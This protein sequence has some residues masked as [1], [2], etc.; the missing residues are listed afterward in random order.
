MRIHPRGL[1]YRVFTR[2]SFGGWSLYDLET[3]K[4][5]FPEAEDGL[6]QW[7]KKKMHE[8]LSELKR[9]ESETGLSTSQGQLQSKI[10]GTFKGSLTY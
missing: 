8:D 9:V 5:L 7:V 2:E 1:V 6:N 4:K 3:T 10:N